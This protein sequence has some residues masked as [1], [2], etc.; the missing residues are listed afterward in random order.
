MVSTVKYYSFKHTTLFKK[1]RFNML[2]VFILFAIVIAAEPSLSFFVMM[3][4][5]VLSGPFTTLW[6]RK[7]R[8]VEAPLSN[9]V[10]ISSQEPV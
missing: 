3:L 7:T 8:Q 1:T 10:D 2:V 9:R 6:L 5:Y 4:C